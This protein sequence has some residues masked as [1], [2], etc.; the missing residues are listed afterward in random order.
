[1]HDTFDSPARQV[2]ELEVGHDSLVFV[3]RI[4]DTQGLRYLY[5]FDDKRFSKL[6]VV[7]RSMV[8]YD[9]SVLS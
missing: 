1:M 6:Y 9:W 4:V 2:L 8:S 7:G 3:G 5:V